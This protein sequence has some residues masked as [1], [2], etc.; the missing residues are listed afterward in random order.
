MSLLELS[1]ASPLLAAFS[2]SSSLSF[3]IDD[4]RRRRRHAAHLFAQ[5][6]VP[7]VLQAIVSENEADAFIKGTLLLIF[8]CCRAKNN[9]IST[10]RVFKA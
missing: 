3:V 8:R 10:T 9:N 1:S 7:R 2:L 6:V 4:V 5:N